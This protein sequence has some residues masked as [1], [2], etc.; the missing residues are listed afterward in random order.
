MGVVPKM[1]IV[2]ERANDVGGWFVYHEGMVVTDPEDYYLLLNHYD[3]S[4]PVDDATVWNDTAPTSTVFSIGT[5]DDVNGSTDTFV[6]YA[7]ADVE[8]FSLMGSY[9]GNSNAAGPLVYTGFKPS[10]ILL[11][12]VGRRDGFI[13]DSQRSPYNEIDDGAFVN[14]AAAENTTYKVDFLSNGFKIRSTG[15]FNTD[16]EITIFAA[17]AEYP[18]GGVDVTPSTTF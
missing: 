8:G 12:G 16:G 2:K 4:A 1:V 11:R 9:N 18:F 3:P 17:F 14:E 6:Y 7:F 10:W 5:H 15:E 13:Y